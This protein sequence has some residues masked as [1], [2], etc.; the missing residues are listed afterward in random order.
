MVRDSYIGVWGV[1]W[2]CIALLK[3]SQASPARPSGMRSMKIKAYEEQ[4]F[5]SGDSRSMK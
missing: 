5:Y 4:D 3:V 1:G 2:G